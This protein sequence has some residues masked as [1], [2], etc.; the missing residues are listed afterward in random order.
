MQFAVHYFQNDL[1]F[2]LCTLLEANLWNDVYGAIFMELFLW[3]R[4]Y[5][6]C[7][8]VDV[9]ED[10]SGRI[11]GNLWITLKGGKLSVT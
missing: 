6:N 10:C 3:V 7:N 9:R 2:H 5:R 8:C 4:R 11:N 1:N